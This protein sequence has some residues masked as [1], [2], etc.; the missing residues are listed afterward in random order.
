MLFP[1]L[2]L[3]LL[4]LAP[5]AAQPQSLVELTVEEREWLEAHGSIRL[6]PDPAGPPLEF[7][8][9]QGLYQGI[10]ADYA[11]LLEQRLG[12]RFEQARHPTHAEVVDATRRGEVDLWM[13]AVRTDE[14]EEY[15]LFT[16]PYLELPVVIIARREFRG[17]ASLDTM[18]G[19]TVAVIDGYA[20][21]EFVQENFPM[22]EL[23]VVPNIE[24]G[25]ERVSFGAADALAAP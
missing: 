21:T 17:I 2:L 4:V 9:E 15:M 24:T 16:E 23:M 3:L 18:E 10:A 22:L 19:M 7:I 12:I 6:G 1:R 25:L 5:A 20:S 11:A 14:R 8:D 13:A